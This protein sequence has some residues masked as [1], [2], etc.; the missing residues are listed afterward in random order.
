[1][2]KAKARVAARKAIHDHYCGVDRECPANGCEGD[3]DEAEFSLIFDAIMGVYFP[4]TARR[5]AEDARA[6]ANTA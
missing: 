5:N 4:N 3:L 1:M 2:T 6:L